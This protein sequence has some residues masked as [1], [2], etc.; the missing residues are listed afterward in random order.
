MDFKKAGLSPILSD[1]IHAE[2]GGLLDPRHDKPPLLGLPTLH[3]ITFVPLADILY[4]KGESS[5]TSMFL[6][7]KKRQMI[8]RTLKECE[9]ILDPL[10]F[11]RIHKSYLVNLIH[12]R[13]Y[14]KGNDRCL[15]LSDGTLL[16]ITP[17]YRE[18]FLGRVYHL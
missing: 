13:K 12:L 5:Q 4:C 15:E 11:C 14:H 7:D 6:I 9:E 17:G 8:N 2:G 16:E 1:R 10:G 18:R 3:G